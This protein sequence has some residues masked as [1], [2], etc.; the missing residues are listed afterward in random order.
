MTILQGHAEENACNCWKSKSWFMLASFWRS[1]ARSDRSHSFSVR[2]RLPWWRRNC[3]PLFSSRF[4]TLNRFT[5]F[6]KFSRC[7]CLRTRDLRADSRFDIIRLRF[8]SSMMDATRFD[9]SEASFSSA[10]VRFG[11]SEPELEVTWLGSGLV[12]LKPKEWSPS[13]GVKPYSNAGNGFP[14]KEI[15]ESMVGN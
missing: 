6:R 2:K 15:A 8:R 14:W 13:Q 4:S 3:N 7:L 9:S 5:W 12:G 1:R 11:S 10:W